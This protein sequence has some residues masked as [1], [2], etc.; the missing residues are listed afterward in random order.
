MKKLINDPRHVVRE[1]LEG[2]ADLNPGLTLLD[3]EDVIVRSG[4]PLS[5]RPVAV[6]SGVALGM[7]PPMPAMSARAC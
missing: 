2:F 6:L 7:N 3:G 1:M 5:G 4:L